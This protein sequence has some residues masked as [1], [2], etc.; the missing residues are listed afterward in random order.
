MQETA[1]IVQQ[2]ILAI[3]QPLPIH[4]VDA[5]RPEY[6]EERRMGTFSSSNDRAGKAGLP[7]SLAD[8]VVQTKCPSWGSMDSL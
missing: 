8:G 7:F 5:L 6:S 4:T 1:N 3:R 2:Y